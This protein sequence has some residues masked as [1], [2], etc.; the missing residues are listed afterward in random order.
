[1]R[2]EFLDKLPTCITEHNGKIISKNEACNS[3]CP[4]AEGEVCKSS[5]R[6]TPGNQI[7]INCTEGMFFN[8]CQPMGETIVDA[9]TINDGLTLTTIY[10]PL[11]DHIQKQIAMVKKY[12][13]SKR[14]LEVAYLMLNG[15]SNE[16]ITK[17]LFI[18]KAT[19]KT[20][21]NSIYK[22]IPKDKIYILKIR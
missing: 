20:H 7:D 6:L 13:L 1:M 21:I 18:S 15:R 8:K 9:V 10:Y 4:T 17:E 11:T 16:A 2:K 5:S 19:L 12:D 3:L 22:K 14:E